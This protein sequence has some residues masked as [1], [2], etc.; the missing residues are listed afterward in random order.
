LKSIGDIS[1]FIQS[2]RLRD[3]VG[4]ED[5]PALTAVIA[6]EKGHVER[7]VHRLG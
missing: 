2:T 4:E 1:A 5:R 6:K 7:L 3:L